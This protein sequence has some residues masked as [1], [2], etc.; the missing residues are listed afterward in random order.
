MDKKKSYSEMTDNELQAARQ[1]LTKQYNAVR[2]QQRLAS[3]E[4]DR[5]EMASRAKEQ[6]AKMSPAEKD[7]LLQIIQP[8]GIESEEVVKGVK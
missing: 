1:G 4:L 2:E 6:A 3:K 7:A 5:R 8:V